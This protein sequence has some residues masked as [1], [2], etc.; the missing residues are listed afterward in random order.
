[1]LTPVIKEGEGTPSAPRMFL[2][3]LTTPFLSFLAYILN[4]GLSFSL[5]CLHLQ[6]IF[7]LIQSHIFVVRE[8]FSHFLLPPLMDFPSLPSHVWCPRSDQLHLGRAWEKV[9]SS[10]RDRKVLFLLHPAMT[11]F[12][13]QRQ[14]KVF[15]NMWNACICI[16]ACRP[17]LSS[18]F[19]L[20]QFKFLG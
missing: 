5:F 6:S 13:K 18:G 17:L 10:L 7:L 3:F 20:P 2:S 15:S 4:H 19:C 12:R 8:L 14:T 11:L 16:Q 9:T 1:M